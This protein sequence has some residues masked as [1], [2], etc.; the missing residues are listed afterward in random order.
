MAKL[1]AVGFDLDGT[2]I[3]SLAL[4]IELFQKAIEKTTGRW[5][6][7]DNVAAEF[8][9]PEDTMIK[10]LC[11]ADPETIE[12]TRELYYDLVRANADRYIVYEGVFGW[13][14]QLKDARVPVG[15]YTARGQRATN[16]LLEYTGLKP[17]FRAVITGE[18]VTQLKPH[19][20]GLQALFSRLGAEPKKSAY[21]GDSDSDIKMAKA[22]GCRPFQVNW[23]SR[24]KAK[25]DASIF[26][27]PKV[28]EEVLIEAA[29]R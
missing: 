12:P 15:L 4:T 27:D 20:E 29:R 21:V 24:L 10:I 8:G 9:K 22:A 2:L 6:S 28:F 19:V 25:L 17:H 26:S 14:E 23:D 18:D 16:F 3:D 5:L 7:T 1:E 11:R 13:L